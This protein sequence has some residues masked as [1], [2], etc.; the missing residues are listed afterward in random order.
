MNS[1]L[2]RIASLALGADES[3]IE[4]EVQTVPTS[5]TE[6]LMSIEVKLDGK[7]LSSRQEYAVFVALRNFGMPGIRVTN[8]Q[9]SAKA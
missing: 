7:E 6:Y 1:Q 2:R 4:A 5:Q 3:R 9:V 8:L